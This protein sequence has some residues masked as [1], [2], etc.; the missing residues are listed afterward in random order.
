MTSDGEVAAPTAADRP[1][2]DG[3]DIRKM[4]M[5]EIQPVARALARAFYDD[6]HFRCS[7]RDDAKRMHRL[8]RGFTT[9]MGRV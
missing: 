4:T 5:A 9:F 1:R 3:S 8:E 7:V 6:P 2:P